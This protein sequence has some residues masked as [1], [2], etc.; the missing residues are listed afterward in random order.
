ML[1]RL[2]IAALAVFSVLMM[3]GGTT[4]FAKELVNFEGDYAPGSI[5]VVN[6][7]R[8]LYYVLGDG[9]AIVYPVAVGKPREQWTGQSIVTRMRENPSWS[10]TRS[11]RRKNPR[12]PRYMPPG[13]K[14]PLGVRAIYLGWSAYRIHG[15]ISPRSIGRA[16]SSGC[17][18]MLNKHVVD[19]YER[20]HIGAPVYVVNRIEAVIGR[21]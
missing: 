2:S 4:G 20:V 12:L 14:N 1:V 13:P 15:T 7:E 17:F 8:K 10:P 3:G 11:M 6:S 19:L 21:Q 16:A 9:Q 18:R 5:I